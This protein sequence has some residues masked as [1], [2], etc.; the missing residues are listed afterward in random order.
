MKKKKNY[1][2][3][4]NKKIKNNRIYQ[5]IQISKNCSTL[6]QTSLLLQNLQKIELIGERLA[7]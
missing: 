5:K 3:N 7:H 6:A 2:I 4:N 1:L